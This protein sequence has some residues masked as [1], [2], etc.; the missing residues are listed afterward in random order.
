[1]S[2]KAYNP[3]IYLKDQY[4]A[5]LE[6]YEEVPTVYDKIFKVVSGVKGSGDKNTQLL[7]LGDL[8]RHTVDGQ[9]INFETPTEGWAYY[10]KYWTLSKGIILVY[11]A[12]ED[13]IKV[14]NAL[15][16]FASTLAE[17]DKNTKEDF[18]ARV[19]NNGGNTGGDFVFNGSHQGQSA[20]YGDMM[21]DNQSFF[22]V[23]GD[24]WTTKG[25]GTYYNS[26]AGLTL[27]P[28]NFE[29]IYVLHT[30]TNNITE[31]DRPRKNAVDT[32][33]VAP[34]ADFLMAERI[35][36][37]EKLPNTQLNDLNVYAG[38]GITTI[39]WDYL[40]DSAFYLGKRQSEMLQFHERQKPSIRTFVDENNRN[41]KSSYV[42]RY[43]A[44]V[45]GR[46]WA[47]GGGSLA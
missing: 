31:L 39:A 28:G 21:Y 44:L 22:V 12:Q 13:S 15:K 41:V 33:L 4:K 27:T 8:D 37:S 43:G 19:F 2:T 9:D 42:V 7:G 45:K 35:T 36:K 17:S 46:P 32:L 25:G 30:A 23:S 38:L 6:K 14:A 1:M 20:P 24:N 11:E 47:R 29:T 40:D 5:V 10:V 3:S 16:F 18:A 26:V 34:G